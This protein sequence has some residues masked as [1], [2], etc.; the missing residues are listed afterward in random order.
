M[1]LVF[2]RG[3]TQQL[4]PVELVLFTAEGD[5]LLDGLDQGFE[6]VELRN[7]FVLD[8]YRRNRK[9]INFSNYRRVGLTRVVKAFVLPLRKE[10]IIQI[11]NLEVRDIDSHRTTNIGDGVPVGRTVK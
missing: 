3:E 8:L 5:L 7:H 2:L 6:T 9:R 10:N 1:G 11:L 4:V